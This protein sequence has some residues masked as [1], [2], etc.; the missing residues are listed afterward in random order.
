MEILVDQKRRKISKSNSKIFLTNT[1]LL[2]SRR[3]GSDLSSTP[4]NHLTAAEKKK[5]ENW[6]TLD[7]KIKDLQ[8]LEEEEDELVE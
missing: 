1:A 5:R 8:K 3:E 2:S 4:K 7:R 6:K